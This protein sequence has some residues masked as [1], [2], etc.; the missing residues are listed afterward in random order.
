VIDE[1]RDLFEEG[2]D[3]VTGA[4]KAGRETYDEGTEMIEK[5][6]HKKKRSFLV[7]VLASGIIGAGIALLLAKKSGKEVRGDIRR[8]AADAREKLASAIDTGKVLYLKGRKTVPAAVKEGRKAVV[9][10]MEK[11]RHAS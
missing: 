2:R 9:H 3:V 8:I 5:L 7:P 1:G 10:E 11:H 6:M 4:I